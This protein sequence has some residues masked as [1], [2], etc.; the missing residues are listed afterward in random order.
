MWTMNMVNG[1]MK[2]MLQG[3]PSLMQRNL[4]WVVQVTSDHRILANSLIS[5]VQV[6]GGLTLLRARNARLLKIMLL[7]SLLWVLTVWYGGEELGMLL[8]GRASA[9]TGAPDA[10]LL[11]GLLTLAGLR[12]SPNFNLS[13][14]SLWEI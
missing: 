13:Q 7:A 3:Q 4:T 14:I 9:L 2:P 8:T 5:V 1:I 12:P 11:Y 10:V 6:L